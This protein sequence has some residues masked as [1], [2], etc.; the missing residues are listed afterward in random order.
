MWPAPSACLSRRAY[1][2]CAGRWLT[3]CTS[4]T[5]S[6]HSGAICPI[7]SP[8]MMP[9]PM[10]DAYHHMQHTGKTC[11]IGISAMEPDGLPCGYHE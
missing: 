11:F 3:C 10:L 8:L 9:W 6:R 2:G 1:G 5:G 7:R 4:T